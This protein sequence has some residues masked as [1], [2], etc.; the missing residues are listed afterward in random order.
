MTGCSKN[1]SWKEEFSK[2]VILFCKLAGCS[3]IRQLFLVCGR[4][5]KKASTDGRIT[6]YLGR[7]DFVDHVTGSDPIDGVIHI[8]R[9]LYVVHLSTTRRHGSSDGHLHLKKGSL[10]NTLPF[11]RVDCRTNTLYMFLHLF[12]F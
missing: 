4:V 8:D 11:L 5:F 10:P 2:Y 12:K 9:Y 3:K 6:V 7:R 1:C